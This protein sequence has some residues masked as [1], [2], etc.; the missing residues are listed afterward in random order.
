M[1]G[2]Y[3]NRCFKYLHSNGA[4][5]EENMATI[6]KIRVGRS[7]RYFFVG[8]PFSAVLP[9]MQSCYRKP[10]ISVDN[11][12]SVRIEYRDLYHERVMRDT[13]YV[14]DSIL[15]RDRGDTV[16]MYRDR[17]HYVDRFLR[18]TI[19]L[20]DTVYETVYRDR[21]TVEVQ[22]HIP[23]PYRIAM[24]VAVVAVILLILIVY[25]RLRRGF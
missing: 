15:I 18:D 7:I 20:V 10:A 3:P 5:H 13:T 14:R 6:S 22:R 4:R 12:D 8:A 25:S 2:L 19:R 17:Y 9:A 11:R 16:I 24:A 1:N 21:V 23:R